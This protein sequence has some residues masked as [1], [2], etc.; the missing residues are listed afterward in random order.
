MTIIYSTSP[1]SFNK[2]KILHDQ[3]KTM[4]SHMGLQFSVLSSSNNVHVVT[5]RLKIENYSSG[6]VTCSA[7]SEKIMVLFMA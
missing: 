5:N 2:A 3:N 6:A 1:A 7:I 4:C